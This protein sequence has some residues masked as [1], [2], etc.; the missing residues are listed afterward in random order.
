MRL[1]RFGDGSKSYTFPDQ[2]KYEDNFRDTNAKHI[3]LFG[4]DG[5]FDPYGTNSFPNKEG[6]VKASWFLIPVQ[7]G[8]EM[9]E[10]RDAVGEMQGW[11]R[12]KLYIHPRGDAS[13]QTVEMRWCYAKVGRI[14]IVEEVK[15]VPHNIQLVQ[16]EF[17]V[18]EPYWLEV[19]NEA[20]QY[21]EAIYSTDDYGSSASVE[22][23]TT[24][25]HSWTV[26]VAGNMPT[27]AYFK[28]SVPATKFTNNP[29]IQ[30]LVGGVVQDEVK[31]LSTTFDENDDVRINAWTLDVTINGA[32]AYDNNFSTNHNHWFMLEPGSN[33]LKVTQGS[34]DQISI[35]AFWNARYR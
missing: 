4:H 27:P 5:G 13:D 2:S 34:G 35:Q 20:P 8:D 10:L 26:T 7:G 33:T 1:V 24:Q 15:K 16:A 29:I 28:I 17:E 18:S 14:K 25:T 19:G 23:A 11:G 6:T 30:R 12:Q 3:K 32:D 21:G 31:F 22:T 9:Y